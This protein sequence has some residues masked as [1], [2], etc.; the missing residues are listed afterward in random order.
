MKKT[1][2]DWLE[3]LGLRIGDRIKIQSEQELY[4]VIEYSRFIALK[5]DNPHYKPQP[6]LLLRGREYTVLPSDKD[7]AC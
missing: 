7:G 2:N 6:I 5:S 4:T 3:F 1:T